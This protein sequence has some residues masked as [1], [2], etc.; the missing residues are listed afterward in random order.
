MNSLHL[1][2]C[3]QT[4]SKKKKKK[5]E[6]YTDALQKH[7]KEMDEAQAKFAETMK[8]EKEKWEEENLPSR[9]K[10]IDLMEEVGRLKSDITR[11]QSI[12]N[13]PQRTVTT[14]T[15]MTHTNHDGMPGK[16]AM[17]SIARNKEAC[18]TM[19]KDTDSKENE[20]IIISKHNTHETES[21]D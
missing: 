11:L 3:L 16:V 21:M 17:G 19:T 8:K 14:V 6:M 5:K 1:F 13:C 15:T 20:W 7:K 10:I 9:Q 18:D 12:A 4:T 2:F